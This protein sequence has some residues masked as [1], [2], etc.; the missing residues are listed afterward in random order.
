MHEDGRLSVT[1][2]DPDRLTTLLGIRPEDN[3]IKKHQ[4]HLRHVRQT[5]PSEV[6]KTAP[7]AYEWS[8]NRKR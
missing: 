1:V 2:E 5:W 6:I 8:P 3:W 7:G 4:E